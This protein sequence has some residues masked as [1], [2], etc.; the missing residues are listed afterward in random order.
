MRNSKHLARNTKT[1]YIVWFSLVAVNILVSFLIAEVIPI[2]NDLQSL[3]RGLLG[4]A[5]SPIQY[6]TGGNGA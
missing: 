4:S 2:F 5:E 3:N 1:H 6:L